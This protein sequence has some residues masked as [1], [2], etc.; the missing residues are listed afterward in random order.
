MAIK[1]NKT[2]KNSLLFT[3][4]RR[5]RRVSSVTPHFLTYKESAREMV[6]ARIHFWNQYFGFSYNRVAIRNQKTCW[7]S[8][9]S[10]KNLNFSYKIIFLPTHLQDYIVL[11]ELC[12]LK[13]LHHGPSFWMLVAEV[14]PDYQDRMSELQSIERKATLSDRNLRLS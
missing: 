12:H 11:H 14:M 8:C 10:L 2:R 3:I 5:R 9:T 6:L 7:G 1:R 13:E 4:R